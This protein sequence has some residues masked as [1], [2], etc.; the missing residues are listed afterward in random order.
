MSALMDIG[1]GPNLNWPA[2]TDLL[3]V[4]GAIVP[5]TDVVPHARHRILA[6]ALLHLRLFLQDYLADKSLGTPYPGQ[7][8]IRTPELASIDEALRECIVTTMGVVQLLRFSASVSP[9]VR[10]LAVS[11][12]CDTL[13]G[14]IRYDGPVMAQRSQAGW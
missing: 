4:D 5:T 13:A 10:L 1:V 14:H 12:A 8:C 11:F 7:R 3:I 9:R 6:G 2:C